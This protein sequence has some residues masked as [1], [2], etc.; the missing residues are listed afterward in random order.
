MTPQHGKTIDGLWYLNSL[1]VSFQAV[2]SLGILGHDTA[3]GKQAWM[4]RQVRKIIQCN[5]VVE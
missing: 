5:V 1:R 4:N 2:R 3:S